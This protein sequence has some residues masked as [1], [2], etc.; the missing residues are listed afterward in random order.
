MILMD[1]K[2]DPGS[3]ITKS[4]ESLS[5]YDFKSKTCNNKKKVYTEV[6]Y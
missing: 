1:L 2:C 6:I 4:L 5:F 3:L